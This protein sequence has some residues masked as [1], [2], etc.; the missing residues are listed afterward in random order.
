VRYEESLLLLHQ[1]AETVLQMDTLG[2]AI[3]F[4]Y[5]MVGALPAATSPADRRPTKGH[6]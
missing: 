5:G 1:A 2:Q 3:T 6:R 4:R